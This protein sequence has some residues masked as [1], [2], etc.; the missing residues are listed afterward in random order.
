MN[1]ILFAVVGPTPDNTPGVARATIAFAIWSVHKPGCCC[2]NSAA[3]PATN[4]DAIDVPTSMSYEVG[5]V[6]HADCTGR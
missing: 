1:N 3:Y 2:A 6:I 4:G 5:D